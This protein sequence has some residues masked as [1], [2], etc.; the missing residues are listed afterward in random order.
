M[1]A[2]LQDFLAAD[3]NCEQMEVLQTIARVCGYAD[4]MTMLG[5]AICESDGSRSL[6]LKV[7]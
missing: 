1:Q 2:I 4:V 7:I 5:S 3:P 6:T